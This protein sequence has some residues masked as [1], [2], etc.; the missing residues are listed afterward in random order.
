MKVK[1]AILFVLGMVCITP[2][3]SQIGYM[4]ATAHRF[5]VN[6]GVGA[7]MLFGDFKNHVWQPAIVDGISY[8]ISENVTITAEGEGG[9]FKTGGLDNGTKGGPYI[10]S[11]FLAGDINVKF[12]LPR[13][14]GF[15]PNSGVGR[16]L[17]G[18]YIGAGVGATENFQ[19]KYS[20][21]KPVKTKLTS[22][23][24]PAD[25]TPIVPVNIGLNIDLPK[26]FKFYAAQYNINF[27]FTQSLGDNLDYYKPK[28]SDKTNDYYM[29][30]STG[31][32]FNFGPVGKSH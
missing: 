21:I 20:E 17:D 22:G 9:Y 15:V 14:M 5:S 10:T 27:Q 19:R 1:N 8:N 30:I 28:L 32:V 31:L 12:A 3:Y 6:I 18:L 4:P 25:I 11:L 23:Y 2:A 26:F 24:K 16:I 29:L 7:T 13:I